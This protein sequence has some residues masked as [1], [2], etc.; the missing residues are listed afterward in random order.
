MDE[1]T[2]DPFSV[3]N[4]LLHSKLHFDTGRVRVG[5]GGGW[6]SACICCL[7]RSHKRL[8]THESIRSHTCALSLISAECK[9]F[10]HSFGRI[11]EG[12]VGGWV[13]RTMFSRAIQLLTKARSMQKKN[14]QAREVGKK[15]K[16]FKVLY[17]FC[18]NKGY[19]N[20]KCL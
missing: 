20:P 7:K 9:Q 17:G 11:W 10:Q 6:E 8:W 1:Q 13:G 15:K 4:Q 12:R 5:G 14:I 2:G 16:L 18:D 19:S 3:K